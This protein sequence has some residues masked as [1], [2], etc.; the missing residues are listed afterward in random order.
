LSNGPYPQSGFELVNGK[1]ALSKIGHL[2]IKL[3]RPIQGTIKTCTLVRTS[4]GKWYA[5][6]SCDEVKPQPAPSSS[7]EAGIDAGLKTF[8]YLSTDEKIENPRFFRAE[9]KALAKAQRRLSKCPKGSS[10]R[11]KARKVVAR[12]HERIGFRRHNFI[13]QESRKLV[14]RF[15]LI[16]V[17]ALVVRNMLRNTR[18][19]KSIADAAWSQFFTALSDKAAEADRLLVRVNPVYT[20]QTCSTCGHRQRLP[21]SVRVFDCEK[22]ETVT[23]RDLNASKN[24]LGLGRQSLGLP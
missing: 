9:E 18:L 8:A 24:I 16:V 17:E 10:M 4:T 13:H 14:N 23:E 3:H 12:V 20:S 22:C 2:K 11:K 7:A 15:A 5:A 6:F 1:L 19:S 21:L